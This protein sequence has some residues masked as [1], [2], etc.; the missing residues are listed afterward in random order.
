[1]NRFSKS[2]IATSIAMCSATAWGAGKTPTLGDVLQ[3]SGITFSGYIDTSYS[4][5][6]GNG[7]FTSGTANRVY[8]AQ[9]NGFDLHTID[10]SASDLPASG[11]GGMAQLDYGTDA[12][13]DSS[14][15]LPGAVAGSGNT[16][17]DVQ[18]AYFQYATGPLTVMAGKFATLAGEEVI[19]SPLDY[20]FTRGILFG[21]AI[22]ATHTGVRANYAINSNYKLIV[23][24]NNGWNVVT[25]TATTGYG[26]TL[27]LGFQA[28]PIKPLSLTADVYSGDAGG[29]TSGTA[30][31]SGVVGRRDL[32]DLVASYTVTD[33]LTLAAEGDEGQQQ[34]A[35]AVGSSAKWDGV[36][37][38]AN[39]AINSRW[40]VAGRLEYF[41]DKNGFTTGIPQKWKEGTLTLAYM[42][43]A[44][45]ELRGEVRYDKSDKPVFEMVNGTSKDSQSS[46][47]VEA[48]YK[49]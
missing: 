10:L 20:N 31:P 34:N 16:E 40:R 25:P 32:L 38:W 41:N 42:P 9:H 18:Q 4:Y 17:V 22:P 48:L 49:F 21:Y 1:M 8:D 37:G 46:V 35:M 43:T 27:E 12:T 13:V 23:G 2:V 11:F 45:V 7:L 30:A 5:L 47:G 36:G 3:A 29:F 33:A 24:V 14:A 15:G 28:T 26:K 39:Y 19:S 6:T 44:Q